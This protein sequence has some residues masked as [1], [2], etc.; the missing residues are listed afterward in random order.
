MTQTVEEKN[1]AIVCENH[2]RPGAM[3]D[4]TELLDA[5]IA[6]HGGMERWSAVR[7]VDVTFNFAGGLLDLKGYPG[8]RRPSASLL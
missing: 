2:N 4:M 7:S 3:T 1:K 8:H 5:V 6:A